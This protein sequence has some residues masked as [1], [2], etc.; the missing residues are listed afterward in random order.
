MN[1][2]SKCK[3]NDFDIDRYSPSYKVQWKLTNNV[4]WSI[5][6][7]GFS[8]PS[9]DVIT[10]IQ[11]LE[12]ESDFIQKNFHWKMY[13]QRRYTNLMT[14]IKAREELRTVILWEMVEFIDQDFH[15]WIWTV[16]NLF[17]SSQKWT[18]VNDV[19]SWK[20]ALNAWQLS[21]EITNHLPSFFTSSVDEF[22]KWLRLWV[23]NK[24]RDQYSVKG[25]M[26]VMFAFADL[27]EDTYQS[28][29]EDRWTYYL[30]NWDWERWIEYD[31]N[32]YNNISKYYD[33]MK[34]LLNKWL[35]KI[36]AE[37][38]LY[39]ITIRSKIRIENGIENLLS[40][41]KND[42]NS[43][44]FSDEFWLVKWLEE[45]KLEVEKC[46]SLPYN[47][48]RLDILMENRG[49]QKNEENSWLSSI[50]ALPMKE[51]NLEY[52]FPDEVSNFK[53]DRF[54]AN[55]DEMKKG[56]LYGSTIFKPN[57]PNYSNSFTNSN[58]YIDNEWLDDFDIDSEWLKDNSDMDTSFS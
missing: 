43:I 22:E 9:D 25:S 11:N 31:Y 30:R 44:L 39:D 1:F 41:S 6:N 10:K 4:N 56:D 3:I 14:Q 58:T 35:A 2:K 33:E 50:A 8:N 55:L 29:K 13:S 24:I 21:W 23:Y 19:L 17:I 47:T 49:K 34:W 36:N 42:P 15:L 48:N 26:D 27:L 38:A 51:L 18:L 52:I 46:T 57:K 40:L 12:R 20:W 32:D 16:L 45:K 54:K 5:H 37:R 28:F 7:S 53:L